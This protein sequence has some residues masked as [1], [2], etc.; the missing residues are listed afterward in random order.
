LPTKHHSCLH[1]DSIAGSLSVVLEYLLKSFDLR[2]AG[3]DLE[4]KRRKVFHH[5]DPPEFITNFNA[6][7]IE[8]LLNVIQEIRPWC[9]SVFGPDVKDL[10]TLCASIQELHQAL[11][12]FALIQHDVSPFFQNRRLGLTIMER[13]SF[14]YREEDDH[15]ESGK[16]RAL[17]AQVSDSAMGRLSPKAANLRVVK[18]ELRRQHR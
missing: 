11:R 10:P 1:W 18:S 15:Q 13:R 7:S 3:N 4:P 14:S 16:L 8:L 2:V 12:E 5:A 17:V 9:L 6:K